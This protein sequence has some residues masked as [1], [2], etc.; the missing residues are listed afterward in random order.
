M[1]RRKS[2]SNFDLGALVREFMEEHEPPQAELG[3]YKPPDCLIKYSVVNGKPTIHAALVW[4]WSKDKTELEIVLYYCSPVDDPDIIEVHLLKAKIIKNEGKKGYYEVLIKMKRRNRKI[5]LSD[6]HESCLH[7]TLHSKYINE[8]SVRQIARKEAIKE[9]NLHLD[10]IRAFENDLEELGVDLGDKKLPKE[11]E[12]SVKH[13]NSGE[14]DNKPEPPKFL[15]WH[16]EYGPL[17]NAELMREKIGDY[18]ARFPVELRGYKLLFSVI[19]PYNPHTGLV[20]I[21]Y[22]DNESIWGIVYLLTEDQVKQL[23]VTEYDPLVY[24]SS[25]LGFFA[26][27]GIYF[28]NY[29]LRNVEAFIGDGDDYID[30]KLKPSRAYLDQILAASGDLPADYVEKLRKTKTFD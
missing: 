4:F 27:L 17:M 24:S 29:G 5:V 26:D 23:G 15:K 14:D 1:A 8:R 25:Y 18:L 7:D 20:N 30:G 22:D 10:G 13:I 16:F 21:D 6:I 19:D 28:N 3:K 9:I 12:V 2:A 11:I